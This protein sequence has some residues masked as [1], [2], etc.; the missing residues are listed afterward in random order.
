M[1]KMEKYCKVKKRGLQDIELI[2]LE[3]YLKFANYQK[4]ATELLNLLPVY[5][6]I[7]GVTRRLRSKKSSKQRK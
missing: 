3:G 4:I 6:T 2:Y 5:E 7:N 1:E